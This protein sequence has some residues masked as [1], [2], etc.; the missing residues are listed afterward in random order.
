MM[1]YTVASFIPVILA[2]VSAT[3]LS[4]LVFGDHPAFVVPPMA[5]TTL[6][7]LGL[8]L[9]IGVAAGAM[10]AGFVQSV[11]SVGR[12]ARGMAIERRMLLAGA[13]VGAVALVLPEVMGIGYDTVGLALNGSIAVLL[14][15]L[16]LIGK[17]AATSA[18][19]GLGVPGGMIGPSLFI[20][21]MLG[22]L[23]AEIAAPLLPDAAV[24]AIAR[25]PDDVQALAVPVLA[26]RLL[27]TAEA[28][29]A[30]HT[31]ADVVAQT[32]RSVPTPGPDLS[33]R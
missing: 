25:L 15:F 30:R 18:C 24:A 13:F 10:S 11:L 17:V 3:T 1:E 8:V 2:A 4:N 7:E 12:W 21:A 9:V 22:A 26:H 6:S 28:Q 23:L 32:V 31:S 19:I 5:S 29:I 27:L 14:L 20:G 16:L 33:H